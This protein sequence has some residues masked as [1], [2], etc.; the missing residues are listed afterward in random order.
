MLRNNES[1]FAFYA[2]LLLASVL[3]AVVGQWAFGG[4]F[5]SVVMGGAVV[6]SVIATLFAPHVIDWPNAG[7]E[8]VLCGLA[9]VAALVVGCVTFGWWGVAYMLGAL[10]GFLLSKALS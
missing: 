4:A 2:F 7:Q 10:C 5:G 6:V 3:L 9:L 8:V 1:R